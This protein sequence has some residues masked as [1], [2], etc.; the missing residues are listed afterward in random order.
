MADLTALARPAMKELGQK[1]DD[2][3]YAELGARLMLLSRD[4]KM[5]GEF[6]PEEPIEIESLGFAADLKNF[7]LKFFNRV[8][9]QAYELVCGTDAEESKER[10]DLLNAFG[11][12]K[13]AVGPVLAGLLVAHLGLAPL[14]AAAVAAIV[15]RLFFKPAYQAMCD[16]WKGKLPPNE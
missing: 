12:G 7:G 13:E 15:I 16:V 14:I 1:S 8:N 6:K 2:E 10:E 4:P 9:R 5:T 3:L 11:I